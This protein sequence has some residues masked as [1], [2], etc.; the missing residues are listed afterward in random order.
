MI[1]FICKCLFFIKGTCFLRFF[2][3]VRRLQPIHL[4]VNCSKGS[5]VK[6]RLS[7]SETSAM[8][9]KNPAPKEINWE[10]L[11]PES[12]NMDFFNTKTLRKSWLTGSRE[13]KSWRYLDLSYVRKQQLEFHSEANWQQCNCHTS[14]ITWE[15]LDMPIT[16]HA[17]CILHYLKL[18]DGLQGQLHVEHFSIIQSLSLIGGLI[19]A[20][21]LKFG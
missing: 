6:M 15:Y 21:V 13:G 18:L 5:M 11:R 14:D 4:R 19:K 1:L 2:E 10:G 7:A 17:N 3:N 12:L 8:Q 16:S 20:V 9:R